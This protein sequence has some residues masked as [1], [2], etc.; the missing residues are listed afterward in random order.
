MQQ[1]VCRRTTERGSF[2][3]AINSWACLAAWR[4]RPFSC[5]CRPAL[6]GRR[7]W[8]RPACWWGSRGSRCRWLRA[9][10]TRR[11]GSDGRSPGRSPG[12]VG[13][14]WNQGPSYVRYR[15]EGSHWVVAWWS[16]V[17]AKNCRPS[18]RGTD[19]IKKN[20]WDWQE[21]GGVAVKRNTP[22]TS[23]GLPINCFFLLG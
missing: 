21:T 1:S 18:A 7:R 6:A 22:M 15:Y 9:A 14:T 17:V 2:V 13:R 12:R 19:G 3:R 10:G 8:P 5:I 20:V 4:S 16:L 23:S 11:A